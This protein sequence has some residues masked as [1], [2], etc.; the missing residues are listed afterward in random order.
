MQI[1]FHTP[2]H[3]KASMEYAKTKDILYVMKLL[4]HKNIKTT[5]IYT[6]LVDISE[7]QYICKAAK[8]KAEATQLIESG[9]EYVTTIEDCQLYKKRK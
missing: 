6:Q 7:T 3:W 1:H 4:G 2:R 8:T 5:L 9:F